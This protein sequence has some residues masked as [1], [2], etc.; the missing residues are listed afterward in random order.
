MGAPVREKLRSLMPPARQ[1]VQLCPRHP[2]NGAADAFR[3]DLPR[4]SRNPFI[5]RTARIGQS[6]SH[7]AH[8]L[9]A[10]G[11][12]YLSK[13]LGCIPLMEPTM[14]S[15][16]VLSTV[17]ALALVLPMAAPT[18]SFAQ[19]PPGGPAAGGHV[20]GGGA[21]RVGGGGGGAPR[22]G[23]GGGGVRMGGG[24]GPPMGGGAPG[25][26]FSGGGGGGGG[27][28]RGGGGYHRG[29]GGGGFIP[30]AVAGALVGGAIASQGYYGGPGYAPGYYDDQYYDDGAVAVAPAPGGD[31]AVAYCM[32]TY[33][34]YDPTSGT[35]L[36]RDGYRH[37]CP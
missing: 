2:S 27:V 35:Y 36:G 34:S 26:R 6:R 21:P 16:K 15:L 37:P 10:R 1:I 25:P 5:L 3:C 22:M 24:G 31:D 14:I 18:A 9:G 19:A 7:A 12:V 20:S 32:Q 17:A 23:G 11:N 30:G 8:N 29:G 33:R 4:I 13:Q 28:Y